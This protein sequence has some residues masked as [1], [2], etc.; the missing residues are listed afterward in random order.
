M[1][2][3]I[4]QICRKRDEYRVSFLSLDYVKD[5][6][7]KI[8]EKVFEG[9]V[10]ATDLEGVYQIFNLNQPEGYRGR[11]MSVS[12]VVAAKEAA[13]WQYYYCD[14][15]GFKKIDFDESL[16]QPNTD[17]L[18][19]VVY[20]E[21]GKPAEVRDVDPSL[22]GLYKL[23]DTDMIECVYPFEEPVCLICDENGKIHS[24]PLN[25]AL[26]DEAGDIYD[27][28]A[29]PFI[30]CGI[31]DGDFVSLSLEEQVKLQKHYLRAEGFL[32]LGGRI[33]VFDLAE[34]G[35]VG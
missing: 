12:D 27:V 5:V 35:E 13:G 15:V 6:D 23:L 2:V 34:E 26:R 11:S 3:K 18:I 29:G 32:L 22:Q 17:G 30:V 33:H 20:V 10:D 9:S 19:R 8:Y 28:V 14:S 7:P 4:Y 25:R 31:E 1:K 24:R 16:T 21:P